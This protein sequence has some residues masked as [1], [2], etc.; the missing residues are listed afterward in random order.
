MADQVVIAQPV[1][2]QAHAHQLDAKGASL[3]HRIAFEFF[4]DHGESFLKKARKKKYATGKKATE[5]TEKEE[6]SE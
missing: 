3:V 4:E 6:E 1:A 5:G 2:G